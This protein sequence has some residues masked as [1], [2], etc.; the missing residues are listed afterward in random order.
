MNRA[1]RQARVAGTQVGAHLFVST[2]SLGLGPALTDNAPSRY[3][4][5]VFLDGAEGERWQYP[6][7]SEAET[8]HAAV[9]AWLRGER[10]PP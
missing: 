10:P 5:V 7:W 8:G 1:D 3:E 6:T 4:T 2:M 9:V